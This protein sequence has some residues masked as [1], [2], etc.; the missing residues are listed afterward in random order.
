M[1]GLFDLVKASTLYNDY[2]KGQLANRY[3]E[4]DIRDLNI[5][6]SPV[7]LQG[8]QKINP[9]Y[10][11]VVNGRFYPSAPN[12]IDVAVNANNPLKTTGHEAYHLQ[13]ENYAKFLNDT[14]QSK[15]TNIYG[16]NKNTPYTGFFSKI[17]KQDFNKRIEDAYQKYRNKYKL[18][19]EFANTGFLGKA[20]ETMADLQGIEATLPS[21]QTILDTDIGK[22]L[23]KTKEEQQLYL[24]ASLPGIMKA[25]QYDPSLWEVAKDRADYAARV[26]KDKAT[27]SS[28]A[29]AAANAFK[30][31]I[32]GPTEKV[33]YQDPFGDT[34]K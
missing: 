27:A 33:N 25:V 12:E 26:F 19:G 8:V 22:D 6:Q 5:S 30:A 11:N 9:I 13:S 4:Q 31:F 20:H 14:G 34:T 10:S 16:L 21:G 32:S 28:Y 1:A 7:Y 3:T 2:D 29:E 15:Q 24:K 18:G 17:D 23:F